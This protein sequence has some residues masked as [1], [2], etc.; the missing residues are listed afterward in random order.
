MQHGDGS[1]SKSCDYSKNTK[2][3][4]VFN[5]V[6]DINPKRSKEDKD[7]KT[8]YVDHSSSLWEYIKTLVSKDDTT[9]RYGATDLEWRE[10]SSTRQG[11]RHC[12]ARVPQLEALCLPHRMDGARTSIPIAIIQLVISTPSQVII[13]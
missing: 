2:N 12:V 6:K 7:T 10:Q 5:Q 8:W 11:I 4:A 9:R 3:A 1:I 13:T